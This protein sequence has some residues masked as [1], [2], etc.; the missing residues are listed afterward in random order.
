MPAL[1]LLDLVLGARSD[2]RLD[3]PA[4]LVAPPSQLGQLIAEAF[5]PAMT[6][7]EWVA[8]AGEGSEAAVRDALL[9][10]WSAEVLPAFRARY[11]LAH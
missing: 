11:G 7:D 1:D 4:D 9:L 2:S 5:D 3:F 8:W 10:V 6:P